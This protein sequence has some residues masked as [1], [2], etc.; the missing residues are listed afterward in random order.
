LI[1]RCGRFADLVGSPMASCGAG[2]T[3]P[4]GAALGNAS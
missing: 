1:L 2:W 3:Q 4:R